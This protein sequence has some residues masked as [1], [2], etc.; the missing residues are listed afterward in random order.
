MKYF[1][2]LFLLSFQSSIIYSQII[3]TT[4]DG[5]K[6]ILEANKTWKYADSSK[7]DIICQLPSDYVEPK[8]TKEMYRMLKPN[9]SS[10][11]DLKQYVSVD[12]ECKLDD[13]KII[14]FS[15]QPGNG[16]Y[17]LCVKGMKMKYRRTGS[18]FTKYN[19]NLITGEK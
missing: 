1:L 19:E 16:I 4:T 8:S 2:V 11:D 13:V 9:G 10:I 12:N 18:V 7:T 5:K 14:S 6:V 3:A 15:E 17:N